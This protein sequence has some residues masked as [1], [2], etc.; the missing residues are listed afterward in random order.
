MWLCFAG[1][2]WF[3]NVCRSISKFTENPLIATKDPPM[4][5]QD[6]KSFCPDPPVEQ[7]EDCLNLNVYAPPDAEVRL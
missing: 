5:P 3:Y 7:K 1:H 4:C 6:C 2:Q